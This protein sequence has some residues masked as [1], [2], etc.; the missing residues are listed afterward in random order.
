[1]QLKPRPMAEA[2]LNELLLLQDQTRPKGWSMGEFTRKESIGHFAGFYRIADLLRAAEIVAEITPEGYKYDE[3]DPVGISVNL[4]SACRSVYFRKLPP[5]VRY[6]FV[7]EER[8]RQP[9][10]GDWVWDIDDDNRPVWKE[11][12]SCVAGML[13]PQLCARRVEVKP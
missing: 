7:A 4:Q 12:H 6:E 3:S 13:P 2:P 1:M 8:E 10:A 11:V 9:R 5:P